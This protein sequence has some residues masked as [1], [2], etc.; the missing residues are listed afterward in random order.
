MSRTVVLKS[1]NKL[2]HLLSEENGQEGGM[3]GGGRTR[4]GV[5]VPFYGGELYSQPAPFGYGAGCGPMMGYGGAYV[6]GRTPAAC[7]PQRAAYVQ[8]M[9]PYTQQRRSKRYAPKQQQ[10][11]GL[12]LWGD[13]TA[14][15]VANYGDVFGIAKPGQVTSLLNPNTQLYAG[16]VVD[17]AIRQLWGYY[18]STRINSPNANIAPIHVQGL[19][20]GRYLAPPV[21]F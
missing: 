13:F 3:V 14:W 11:F 10:P 19:P 6:A 8:C 1:L 20:P 9:Q 5:Q 21:N 12:S 4:G 15:I 17:N 2:D 16:P 18:K 7:R